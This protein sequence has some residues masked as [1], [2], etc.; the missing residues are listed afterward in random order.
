M[1]EAP[2]QKAPPPPVSPT[3]PADPEKN[4]AFTPS[5]LQEKPKTQPAP[6]ATDEFKRK[7]AEAGFP[8]SPQTDEAW[9]IALYKFG[10]GTMPE[11]QPEP[12]EAPQNPS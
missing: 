6:W 4:A 12:A 2:A 7:V 5:P 9:L 10:G 8:G 11:P 1:S 3:N